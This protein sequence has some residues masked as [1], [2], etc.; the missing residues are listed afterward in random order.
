MNDYEHLLETELPRPATDPRFRRELLE[1]ILEG[2]IEPA[3]ITAADPAGRR[4]VFYVGGAV[5]GAAAAIAAAF[6][7]R[8]IRPTGTDE[9][10]A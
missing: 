2:Q 3:M 4:I 10:A 1:R 7:W 6:G 9:E 8:H 5:M